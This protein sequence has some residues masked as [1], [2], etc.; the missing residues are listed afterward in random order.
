MRVKNKKIRKISYFCSFFVFTI[1][2]ITILSLANINQKKFKKIKLENNNDKSS[3][4]NENNKS[5]NKV[6]DFDIVPIFKSGKDK[7]VWLIYSDDYK[8]EEQDNFVATLQEAVRYFFDRE[9]MRLFS[10]NIN[11]Y[12]I[13]TN[14]YFQSI[15]NGIELS[16]SQTSLEK[17]QKLKG[18][19]QNNYLDDGAKI[20]ENTI[21]TK[22]NGRGVN[23]WKIYSILSSSNDYKQ[24]SNLLLHEFGHGFANLADEYDLDLAPQTGPNRVWANTPEDKIPWKEFLGFR[25]IGKYIAKTNNSTELSYIP[26][27]L[28]TCLMSSVQ[29][30]LCFCT[31]CVFNIHKAFNRALDNMYEFFI[32]DPELFRTTTKDNKSIIK[33]R[34][35]LYNYTNKEKKVKLLLKENNSVIHQKEFQINSDSLK[36]LELEIT[37]NIEPYDS[38]Y[39]WE[40]LDVEHNKIIATH[41][42]SEEK[43]YNVNLQFKDNSGQNIFN[44]KY[45]DIKIRQGNSY[46]LDAPKIQGYEFVKHNQNGNEIKNISS[47]HNIEYHYKKLE[48]KE[49]FLKLQDENNKIIDTK[50]IYVYEKEIFIPNLLDFITDYKY[51]IEL[52]QEQISYD[53]ITEDK[54]EV[55]YK[56]IKNEPKVIQKIFNVKQNQKIPALNMVNIYKMNGEQTTEGV[57]Y[58]DNQVKWDVVGRYPITYF[59]TDYYRDWNK[60]D[61]VVEV[62]IEKVI[63]LNIVSSDDNFTNPDGTEKPPEE[64]NSTEEEVIT[65][66]QEFLNTYFNNSFTKPNKNNYLQ[67]QN[68]YKVYNDFTDKQKNKV[69]EIIKQNKNNFSGFESYEQILETTNHFTN[70]ITNMLEKLKLSDDSYIKNVN[71]ENYKKIVD[72]EDDFNSLDLNEKEFVDYLLQNSYLDLLQ[73]ANEFINKNDNKKNNNLPMIIGITAPIGLVTFSSLAAIVAIY[74]KKKNK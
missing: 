43:F 23:W 27:S 64:N 53:S 68:S 36:N 25:H 44:L 14:S 30:E 40:V 29:K 71:Q 5:Q 70:K 55:I 63:Y 58:D 13:K 66:A 20:I 41:N 17:L 60:E 9:P 50:K 62:K 12:A 38:K 15:N 18:Q 35:V 42:S 69:N 11:V 65:K 46:K 3:N 6:V 74:Y 28:G 21:L 49:L 24:L 72:F 59:V 45:N 51:K 1:S 32:P 22:K 2:A 33:F 48:K 67:I 10:Q 39:S 57:S 19:I 37:N 7:L 73:K 54:K 34:T 61:N 26:R 31:V 8:K 52:P 56:A 16:L 4:K 47:N